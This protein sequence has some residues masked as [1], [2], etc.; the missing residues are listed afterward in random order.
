MPVAE[1]ARYA[2]G[3]ATFYPV[4]NVTDAVRHALGVIETEINQ[5]LAELNTKEQSEFWTELHGYALA[6]T[7]EKARPPLIAVDHLEESVRRSLELVDEHIR[8]HTETLS[9]GDQHRFWE[10]LHDQAQR[11]IEETKQASPGHRTL[12]S[13]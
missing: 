10:I 13:I 4:V 3:M 12:S 1:H 7:N 2:T 8:T 11:M 5:Q 9:T 6:R